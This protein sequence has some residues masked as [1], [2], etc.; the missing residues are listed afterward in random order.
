MT[1]ASDYEVYMQ[2]AHW[3]MGARAGPCA[4]NAAARESGS[5]R[6]RRLGVEC[7]GLELNR[8]LPFVFAR[9]SSGV[10]V[11][12]PSAEAA[13]EFAL[14]LIG[15]TKRCGSGSAEDA[16]DVRST[17]DGRPM[18]QRV[19]GPRVRIRGLWI[20]PSRGIR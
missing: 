11:S 19:R 18:Q 8:N 3:S 6:A 16:A 12:V 4:E 20:G 2:Y 7:A 10:N 17:E 13:G 15:C 5:A 14:R 1:D 9:A